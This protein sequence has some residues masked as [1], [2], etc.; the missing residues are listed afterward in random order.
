MRPGLLHVIFIWNAISLETQRVMDVNSRN[1][2]FFNFL[3]TSIYQEVF[4]YVFAYFSAAISQCKM[5]HRYSSKI[6]LFLWSFLNCR[7]L[8]IDT[9]CLGIY[10]G[11]ML[12][13]LHNKNELAQPPD[14]PLTPA[15]KPHQSTDV[16]LALWWS[17][18]RYSL[19]D[20]RRNVG[21]VGFIQPS[22]TKLFDLKIKYDIWNCVQLYV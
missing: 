14:C 10:P 21:R 22:Q 2:L 18:W 15:V 9:V 16:A 19:D 1:S 7:A 11:V 12:F 17:L 4:I 6:K 20:L 3:C 13:L 5:Y 8:Y